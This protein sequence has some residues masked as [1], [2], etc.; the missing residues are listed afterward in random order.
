MLQ[1][2]INYLLINKSLLL[3]DVESVEMEEPYVSDMEL[4]YNENMLMGDRDDSD[5]VDTDYSLPPELANTLDK[6]IRGMHEC[7]NKDG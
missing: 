4:P 5:S 2:V 6:L 7:V 3:L 1:Y